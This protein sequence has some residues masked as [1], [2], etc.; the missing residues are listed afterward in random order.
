[1]KTKKYFVSFIEEGIFNPKYEG[2]VGGRVEVYSPEEP[3]AIEE[4]RFFTKR[5]EEW[6]N[7]RERWDFKDITKKQLTELRRTIEEKYRGGEKIVDT[8]KGLK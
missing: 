2:W 1:M 4:I 7:Y 5:S 6:Y 3:Y 8:V